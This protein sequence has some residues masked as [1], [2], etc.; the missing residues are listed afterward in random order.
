MKFSSKRYLTVL[1]ASYLVVLVVPLLSGSLSYFLSKN[2]IEEELF[3]ANAA[4]LEQAQIYIDK[5]MEQ[6][7]L[8][9]SGVSLNPLLINF[10]S[11]RAPISE[12]DHFALYNIAKSLSV[13]RNTYSFISDFYIYFLNSDLILTP[14][15]VYTPRMFYDYAYGHND[16][17]YEEWYEKILKGT[18]R[19][20]LLPSAKGNSA[21]TDGY[22]T[23][24][25]SLP[26]DLSQSAFANFVILIDKQRIEALFGDLKWLSNGYLYITDAKGEI[27]LSNK[28][29]EYFES[30]L[31]N[32]LDGARGHRI[33]KK[34]PEGSIALSYIS[35][36][37]RHWKYISLMPVG[38]FMERVNHLKSITFYA[39][40]A[41]LLLGFILV[42]ILTLRTY[43]PVKN[44]MR[45]LSAENAAMDVPGGFYE[46]DAGS[47]EDEF[48][49]IQRTVQQNILEKA[50]LLSLMDE[51]K[52]IIRN[53]ILRQILEGKI[54]LGKNFGGSIALA[55]IE[56]PYD[57]YFVVVVEVDAASIK[58]DSAFVC[59]AVS[60]YLA[61]SEN[62]KGLRV[63]MVETDRGKIALLVNV[64]ERMRESST[65][66]AQSLLEKLNRFFIDRFGLHC[67]IGVG[68]CY[69]K[70]SS[71]SLSYS[72]A[73]RA[74]SYRVY[75]EDAAIIHYDEIVHGDQSY[76]Y[77]FETEHQI[78][79]CLKAGEFEK[80]KKLVDYIFHENF[81]KRSLSLEMLSF[82]FSDMMGTL[83][84]TLNELKLNREGVFGKSFNA[85]N[86]F[87]DC[88]TAGEVK[89]KFY[90]LFTAF[91]AHVEE[92]K[93]SHNGKLAK[94]ICDYVDIEYTNSTLCL[95]MIADKFTLSVP[96]LSRFFKEQTG[97]NISA[98]INA[99]RIRKAEE[100]F[101]DPG[102]CLFEI[103]RKTGFNNEATFIRV[104]KK[105][106]GM[107][108]GN[109]RRRGAPQ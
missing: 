82:L 66:A 45:L 29:N 23:Y 24:I 57:G 61:Q 89:Q 20:E 76:Y 80:A 50:R 87:E 32:M 106:T 26:I 88:S 16:F 22:L 85:G 74:L 102:T 34:T 70:A 1:F 56:F 81:D 21:Q 62:E 41:G 91:C 51:Q 59:L 54:D 15:A 25:E 19:N 30:N 12:D 10:L 35:S 65:V 109:F 8:L 103:A 90:D 49:F 47:N 64:D 17:S 28:R 79:T 18:H 78:S 71:V 5:Q 43:F 53:N 48:G 105:V 9:L 97:E 83:F 14:S 7:D 73:L 6:K 42:V 99:L 72:Q 4:I 3:R 77:P 67:A 58:T 75:S 38:L 101:A 68:S 86:C 108:P 46:F 84:K 107:T 100:L 39:L 96:Y 40:F 98:Y 27:I 44:I 52:P 94:S 11:K 13:L 37:N 31:K 60:D 92:H 104:F 55:G 69:G 93:K 33:I 36:T 63:Y 95:Q 2:A